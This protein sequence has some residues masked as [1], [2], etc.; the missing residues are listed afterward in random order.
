MG[1]GKDLLARV[2]GAAHKATYRT[3]GGK[4]GGRA[5]GMPIIELVTTGRRTGKP[6]ATMVAAPVVDGDR[7]V[8]VAAYHGDQRHP[9]WYLN[10]RDNPVVTATM[11]GKPRRMRART[12]DGA[13]RVQLW[14]R[15]VAANDVY[16]KTQGKTSRQFPVVVLEPAVS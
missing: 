6:R 15:I 8:I 1:T 12:V 2:A 10:L 3:T 16:A 14:S 5:M 11:D 7:I 4:V 13:E 9:Q